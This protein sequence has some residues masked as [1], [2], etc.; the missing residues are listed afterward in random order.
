[1]DE[2]KSI[3]QDTARIHTI[4][5]DKIVIGP[6]MIRHDPDDEDVVELALQ[7]QREGL[8]EPIGVR[9]N[10]NATYQLLY[11]SRR[12]AAHKQLRHETIEAVFKYVP[13]TKIKT[14]AAMENLGRRQL[15]VEE[16]VDVV[17]HLNTEEG[18]SPNEIASEFGKTRD[19]VLRR[20]RL[21]TMP[22]DLREHVY[23]G[24][25][26]VGAA[27]EISIL[28]DESKRRFLTQQVIATKAKIP[29]VRRM[30]HALK[31]VE[32][33]EAKIKP[34]VEA[35]MAA[36]VSQTVRMDCA[37]CATPREMQDLMMVSVCKD[38]CPDPQAETQEELEDERSNTTG[39]A[40]EPHEHPTANGLHRGG[41]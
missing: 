33:I 19:W 25:I 35:G 15:T 22:E 23:D 7:I 26:A 8:L 38:G 6:Q 31:D 36:V 34:A 20:L 5:I 27:E 24:S 12:V 32:A 11:G 40:A 2:K 4:P 16:E 41:K 3:E 9:P 14:L 37:I 17:L 10:G 29:D 13:D 28:E 21:P 39:G 18:R 30:V 1:M